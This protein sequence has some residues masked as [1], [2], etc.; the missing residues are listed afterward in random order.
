MVI[1][2]DISGIAAY[3]L[4]I[5]TDFDD[6][7]LSLEITRIIEEMKKIFVVLGFQNL[8]D[9]KKGKYILKNEIKEWVDQRI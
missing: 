2:G 4:K 9:A 1:G 6:K 8:E 5:F 7:K 3:F